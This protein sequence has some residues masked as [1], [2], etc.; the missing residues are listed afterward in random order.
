MPR[1]NEV[2]DHW[3]E[4][5]GVVPGRS[6]KQVKCRFCLHIMSYQ[7]DRML[8]Y[9][10]YRPLLRGSRDVSICRMVPPHIGVLFEECTGVVHESVGIAT[11]DPHVEDNVPLKPI[12]SQFVNNEKD[13]LQMFQTTHRSDPRLHDTPP[14]EL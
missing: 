10:G 9:L 12:L 2:W 7:G 14:W 1:R 3:Y 5:K 13:P 4:D 8:A 11:E 6:Q